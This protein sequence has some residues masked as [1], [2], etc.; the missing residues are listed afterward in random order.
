MYL[1]VI[2]SFSVKSIF[3]Q[4]RLSKV[5]IFRG[6]LGN[7]IIRYLKLNKRAALRNPGTTCRDRG[8]SGAKKLANARATI[9]FLARPRFQPTSITHFFS[10]Y[11]SL[12]TIYIY[13][14]TRASRNAS[15][16]RVLGLG[17]NFNKHLMVQYGRRFTLL[18]R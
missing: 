3:H 1:T 9:D 13:L 2:V 17:F 5:Q 16:T 15:W 7:V 12:S 11:T 6:T 4:I 8:T 10:V 18:G 14:Y